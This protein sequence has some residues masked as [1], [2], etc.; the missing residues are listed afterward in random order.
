MNT[1]FKK[2]Q[3]NKTNN[4]IKNRKSEVNRILNKVITIVQEALPKMFNFFSI[5]G[6]MNTMILEFN[7]KTLGIAKMKTSSD[8]IWWRGFR[9]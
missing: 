3:T 9:V 5:Q 4:L 6:N 2:V 7:L 1:V 8:R